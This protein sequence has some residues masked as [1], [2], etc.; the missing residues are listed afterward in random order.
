MLFGYIATQE[1]QDK[2]TKE[3]WEFIS[4][5]QLHV[6][7]HGTYKL[8]DVAKAH[9]DIEGRKTTGKVLFTP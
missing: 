3:L 5:G 2:Y 7:V 1:E 8:K 9:E 6:R 4:K